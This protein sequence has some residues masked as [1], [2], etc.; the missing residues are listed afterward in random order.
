MKSPIFS[1]VRTEAVALLLLAA[2]SSALAACSSN[3]S[4]YRPAPRYT[5][6]TATTPRPA[7]AYT[8][9]QPQ[10]AAPA[11]PAPSTGQFAC[12]KGKCG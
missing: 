2:G 6:P 9:P 3:D 11:A 5:Q 4:N 8:A 7:P 12:G 1:R 10:Y